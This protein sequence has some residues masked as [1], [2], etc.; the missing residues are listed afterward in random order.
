MNLL[1]VGCG[2]ELRG[3][4]GAGRAVADRIGALSLPGVTV[5]SVIQLVPELVT[6]MATA[7]RVVFVDADQGASSLAIQSIGIGHD[8]GDSGGPDRSG[9]LTHHTSPEALL[10]LAAAIGL[11]VPPQ[12]EQ[13]SIPAIGFDLGTSLS[14]VTAAG[15]EEAVQLIRERAAIT[16]NK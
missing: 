2:N 11:R 16:K 5:R 15:V 4:D 7:D 14:A 10:E 6:D 8:S 1:V 13:L 12:V 9:S 3:D